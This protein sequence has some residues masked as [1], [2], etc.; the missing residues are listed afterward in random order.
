LEKDATVKKAVKLY[1]TPLKGSSE[2]E[3]L[4][5][6]LQDYP[7]Y[8][9]MVPGYGRLNESSFVGSKRF[10]TVLNPFSFGDPKFAAVGTV[11]EVV[12]TDVKRTGNGVPLFIV[13]ARGVERFRATRVRQSKPYYVV[14]TEPLGDV[15]EEGQEEAEKLTRAKVME[16]LTN[17]TIGIT[18]MI[19]ENQLTGERTQMSGGMINSEAR[20]LS[21]LALATMLLRSRPNAAQAVLA[22]TSAAQRKALVEQ[23]IADGDS[24]NEV[25]EFSSFTAY[26]LSFAFVAI[27]IAYF[28]ANYVVQ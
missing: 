9:R 12:G 1:E 2:R 13:V 25:Q 6:D 11:M 19:I 21:P 14:D 27:P 23:W 17:D 22:S 5:K 26:A 7:P 3:G 4:E 28:I 20:N 16:A 10:A 8:V 15:A 18:A 24:Q